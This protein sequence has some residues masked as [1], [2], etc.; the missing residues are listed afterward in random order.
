MQ[1]FAPSKLAAAIISASRRQ[2]GFS[3]WSLELQ[4]VTQYSEDD[5]KQELFAITE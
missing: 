3:S 5:I 2:M 1:Y 4:A